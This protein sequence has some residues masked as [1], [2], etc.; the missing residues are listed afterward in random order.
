M[1]NPEHLEIL[2]QGVEKWNEWREQHPE[3]IPDL[4]SAV[5]D[6]EFLRNADLSRA[7]LRDA[8]LV[9]ADFRGANLSGSD[10]TGA[11]LS[12]SFLGK[13][14]L[15]GAHIFY[16]NLDR[17]D[18]SGADFTGVELRFASFGGNDLSQVRG[19][20]MVTHSGQSHLGIDTVSK[21]GGKIPEAFLRGC[22]VSND[23]INYARSLAGDFH[24][25]FISYSSTDQEF[26]EQLH[27]D[28][29][30]KGVRVWFAPHDLPIGARIR[31][32][33]DESI[34]LHDKLLLVLS[35]VG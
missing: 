1:A 27:A 10:L 17:A 30:A 19:L 21:S 9:G 33:I 5:L 20:E 8:S 13:T 28:L 14:D 31:P 34:S 26:A 2:K 22:G 6:S 3:I 18:L 4:S 32:A 7:N 25:C 23:F 16:V 15:S 12:E 11:N 29:Q 35:E 24:S